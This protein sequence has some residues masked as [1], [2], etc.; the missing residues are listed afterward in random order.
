MKR[1]EFITLL[2][3]VESIGVRAHHARGTER[4]TSDP[5]SSQR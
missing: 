2:G 1:R 3:G 4:K 5:H